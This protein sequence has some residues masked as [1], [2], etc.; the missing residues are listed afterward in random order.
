MTALT[1]SF[2]LPMP[3]EEAWPLFTARGERSWVEGWAPSFP[4]REEDE[5]PGSVFVTGRGDR[6]TIWVVTAAEPSR[7]IAY[8]RV[9]PGHTAGTVVVTCRA[10]TGRDTEVTVTY[11]LTALS[12]ESEGELAA[13]AT[14]Y[15]DHISGWR[16]AILRSTSSPHPPP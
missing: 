4:G 7:Q 1:T 10:L 2:I 3:P 8:A 6:V 11:Q 15:A 14:T 9:T 5:S 13:F 16:D 12:R